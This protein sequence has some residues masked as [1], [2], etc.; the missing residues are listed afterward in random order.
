M[1]QKWPYTI[2]TQIH[3]LTL[4]PMFCFRSEEEMLKFMGLMNSTW[5]IDGHDIVTAFDLSS[6][7]TVI[8]LGGEYKYCFD[9]LLIY[10]SYLS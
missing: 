8:D 10:D 6:F 1:D 9:S 7:K 3:L 4:V 5:V 2:Q